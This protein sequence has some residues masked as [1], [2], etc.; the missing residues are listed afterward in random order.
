ME[1]A[2]KTI[3]TGADLRRILDGEHEGYESIRE[4]PVEFPD[5]DSISIEAII[6]KRNPGAGHPVEAPATG[7]KGFRVRF[8]IPTGGCSPTFE[9]NDEIEL[10]PVVLATVTQVDWVSEWECPDGG[11]DGA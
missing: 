6:I 11:S 2:G 3:I 5:Y 1:R 10:D 4:R 8:D 7:A 9:P